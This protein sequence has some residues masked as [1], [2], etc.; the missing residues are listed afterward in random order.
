M[1]GLVVVKQQQGWMLLE[2]M[3]CLA[4]LSIILAGI[5]KQQQWHWQ[6]LQ[7]LQASHGRQHQQSQRQRLAQLMNYPLWL[8]P[9]ALA[10]RQ[11]GSP[12][13]TCQLCRGKDFKVW[14]WASLEVQPQAPS[15]TTPP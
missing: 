4:L 9:E 8:E 1:R 5:E 13:P 2:V 7:Q 15:E 3:V 6:N 14:F 12:Y 11:Q 10:K